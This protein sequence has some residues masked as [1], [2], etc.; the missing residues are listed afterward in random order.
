M[1]KRVLAVSAAL[2]LSA[3]CL[4]A[5]RAV[6]AKATAQETAVVAVCGTVIGHQKSQIP[7]L[8]SYTDPIMETTIEEDEIPL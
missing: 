1:K 2:F 6:P 8:P 7:E 4:G 3:V 5:M